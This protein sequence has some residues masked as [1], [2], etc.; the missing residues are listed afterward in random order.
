MA[1]GETLN[2]RASEAAPESPNLDKQEP[3]AA[4]ADIA[5]LGTGHNGDGDDVSVQPVQFT[6]LQGRAAEGDGQNIELIL[7]ISVPVSVELGNTQ[8]QIQ[9]VLALAPGSVIELDKLASEPVDLL[10]H[11]KLLAQGEVVVVDEN[12]GIRI[13]TIVPPRER[14]SHLG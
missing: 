2:R 14:I 6:P 4:A 12:F 11:G 9:E 3:A 8:M 7:D 5:T 13:T 10:V 1:E